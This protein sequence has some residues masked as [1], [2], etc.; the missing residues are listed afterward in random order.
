MRFAA[1]L[2]ALFVPCVISAQIKIGLIG[3][4]TSHVVAFT[5]I[6]N[7][8]TNP[9]HVPGARVVA[10]Y[11]GG[12]PD[13]ESSRTRMPGFTAELRDKWGVE[14]VDD[15]ATLCS[16]VDAVLLESV[17][18]RKHLPQVRPVFAAGKPVFIDKPLAASLADAE[19][20]ARLAKQHDVAWWSASS[21]RYSPAVEEVK[22]A[23][24]TGAI[25]WGPGPIEPTHELDL[26]W[27][28]IHPV[29]LLYSVMGTGCV[30]L[31]RNYS[32]GADVIVGEWSDGRMGTVR[33]IREGERGYGLVAFGRDEVKVSQDAGGQ[34]REILVRVVKFFQ[35]GKPPVPNAETLEIFRFMHAALKSKQNGGKVVELY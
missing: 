7:D 20:I 11:K 33:T 5:R 25:S 17:D 35:D 15:I 27:Y 34:Y 2:L 9:D 12:S 8:P 31:R 19:E 16:K 21:L 24:L 6:L 30:R 26:S 22:V 1:A 3:L 14:I 13:I 18:G 32:E 29:E 4:D 10:G 23:G 28:G